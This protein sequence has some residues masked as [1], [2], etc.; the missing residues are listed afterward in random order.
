[1]DLPV[2]VAILSEDVLQEHQL[3]LL[4]ACPTAVTAVVKSIYKIETKDDANNYCPITLVPA[5]SKVLEKVIANQLI[6]FLEK[7]NILNK[8]QFGF[9]KNKSTNDAIATFLE[10]I[11]ESLN[12]K[13]Q[14]AIAY[15]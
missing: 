4:W 9:R 1:V 3:G 14:N 10:N 13:K 12:K 11:I 15:Y 2:A 8:S 7:H 6:A 5:L